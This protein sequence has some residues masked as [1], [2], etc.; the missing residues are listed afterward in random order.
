MAKII[1]LE[2]IQKVCRQLKA[3]GKTLVLAG[4]CF[5][6]LHFGHI[7]FLEK[8]KKEGDVLIVALES[9][10]NIKRLKGRERPIHS[11][12]MRAEMLSALETVDYI[13]CLP[14]MEN[15]NDYLELVK[16]IKPN[17][18]AVTAGDP[19]LENKKKQAKI[20]GAKVKIV[21]PLLKTLSTKE[22][23]KNW[24]N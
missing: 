6:V 22:I 24:N 5:D 18:I 19:Q 23:L 2:K 11:Q 9:N 4:G 20:V 15:N 7:K 12:E 10:K 8:A 14:L 3:S 13:V 21:S 17:I 16:R 1:N